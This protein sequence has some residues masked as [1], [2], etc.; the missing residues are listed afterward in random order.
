MSIICCYCCTMFP[1]F[2]WL[3]VNYTDF[4]FFKNC[5]DPKL[6]ET[7]GIMYIFFLPSL[8][9]FPERIFLWMRSLMSSYEY[10]SGVNHLSSPNLAWWLWNSWRPPRNS[11]LLAVFS[12]RCLLYRFLCSVLTFNTILTALCLPEITK[13]PSQ[14]RWSHSPLIIL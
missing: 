7:T 4:C 9:T 14:M 3:P 6:T 2:R 10:M 8:R 5:N 11:D 13:I 12:C 1:L